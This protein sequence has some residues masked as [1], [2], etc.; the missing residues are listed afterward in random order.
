MIAKRAASRVL[1]V[2]DDRA[3]RHA[4]RSVLTKAGFKVAVAKD[5]IEAL[6]RMRDTRF[7][8]MLLDV[9]MPRLDGMALLDRMKHRKTRPRVVV[10]TADDTPE[11]MLKAV[12]QQA[13]QFVRKPIESLALVTL[14]RDVLKGS[15]TPPA[16]DVV[17]ARP[18]W[19]ELVVPCT[20]EAAE[21]I[22]EVMG[23]LETDLPEELRESVSYAFRELLLNAIEW[24]G[25]LDPNRTVRIAYL[26]ARRMLMYRI[27]D[28]GPGFTMDRLEHAAVSHPDNP[29][30]HVHIREEK[31]LRPGGF[32]LLMVRAKVDELLY[33]QKQNEVV[34]VKYLD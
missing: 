24:G 15:A 23:R 19:V 9:W 30:E 1:V 20:R 13:L 12:Q 32:G 29:I 26:R 25:K 4:A 11:T 7:D 27:A 34:F 16:I 22:H 8:L 33:N 5:G 18:S 3:T 31:G 21:R 14:V 10:M 2:D 6:G 17:S 28:P